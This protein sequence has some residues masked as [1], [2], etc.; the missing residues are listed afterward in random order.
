MPSGKRDNGE[1]VGQL[2]VDDPTTGVKDLGP[3]WLLPANQVVPS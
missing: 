1:M 2:L 3:E